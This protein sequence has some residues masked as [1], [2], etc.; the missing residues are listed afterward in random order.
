M[1][2]RR[3]D[4]LHIAPSDSAGGSLRYALRDCGRDD[5]EVLSFRDDLSCGPIAAGDPA[6]RARWWGQYYDDRDIE[7][8]LRGFWERIAETKDRLVLWFGRHSASEY[9]FALACA[10]RLANLPYEY[11]DVTGRQFPVVRRDDPTALSVAVQSVGIMNPN[12]LKSLLGSE[13]PAST[14]FKH[15]CGRVWCRL[16]LENA[17]FRVVTATGLVSAPIDHFDSHI[18]ERA[19]AEWRSVARIVGETMGYNCEPYMQVGDVMLRA[20]LVALVAEGKLLADGD[21][22]QMRS[23]RVRLPDQSSP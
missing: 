18:L 20:R 2:E 1:A 9:A 14:G 22:W 15:E 11:I 7:A 13:Q 16:C 12:M 23:C 8:V 5:D 4:T 3:V 6:E 17:P 19:T 21:P 10:D